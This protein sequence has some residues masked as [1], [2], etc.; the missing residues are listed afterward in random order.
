MFV[1]ILTECLVNG[2]RMNEHCYMKSPIG[3]RLVYLHLT[4]VHSKGQTQ[5][6]ANFDCE[7]LINGD[8]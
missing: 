1:Q 8:R 7:F 2:D 5:G 3:I 4:L 6:R